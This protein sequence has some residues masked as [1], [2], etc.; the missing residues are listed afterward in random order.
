MKDELVRKERENPREII[1]FK[2]K[3]KNNLHFQGAMSAIIGACGLAS[4]IGF[5]KRH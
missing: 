1:K 2:T 4:L 5:I 3:S